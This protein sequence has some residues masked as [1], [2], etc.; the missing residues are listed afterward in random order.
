M[1]QKYEVYISNQAE[2]E[3]YRIL[4]YIEYELLEPIIARNLFEKMKAIILELET[5]P[6][7]FPIVKS[8]NIFRE[9][10]RKCSV[11]NYIIIYNVDKKSK[12]I[13]ISHIFYA[14]KDWM[15]NI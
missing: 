15:K 6:E 7:K 13:S 11:N 5:F 8:K 2:I 3:L 14:K 10:V 9:N 4:D 1:Q 12:R